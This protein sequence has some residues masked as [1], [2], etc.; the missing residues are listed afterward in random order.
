MIL[1]PGILALLFGSALV[2][3]LVLYGC[4]L[5]LRVIR[6]WDW[7]DT[8][9]GQLLLERQ[10]YLISSLCQYA[11]AFQLFSLL[12]F[13]YT[14][15]EI[16]PLFVGAMCATGSL[17]A[18]AT[19]W[20]ALLMKLLVFFAAGFWLV[21][22]HYDLQTDNSPLARIKYRWLFVLLPLIGFDFVLLWRYFLG[23]SPDIITSCCGS[24][25]STSAGN[26]PA[27]IIGLPV[28]PM[29][30][31]FYL[32]SG[33]LALLNL[34]I[35]FRSAAFWRFILAA[36]AAVFL[37]IA[38]L[39]VFSFISVYIYELPTHHCPFDMLQKEYGYIGYPIY[40]CLFGT[41]F[42]DFSIGL[43]QFLHRYPGLSQATAGADRLL[44]GWALMLLIALVIIVSWPFVF[45]EF[46]M[47]PYF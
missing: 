24:L 6:R 43:M 26:G 31:L 9:E 18:N 41:V 27:D 19:G 7:R 1:H 3:L 35:F 14:V 15:E 47:R 33:G 36:F 46:T 11:F 38:L 17:N 21:V 45:S 40:I 5:G 29:I 16:H 25:F 39:S 20:P 2:F 42:L 30:R 34:L 8:G 23:L 28:R 10:T 13:I 12:L 32:A 44:A 37:T 22:N 4:F